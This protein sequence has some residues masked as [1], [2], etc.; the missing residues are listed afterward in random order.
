MWLSTMIPH[1]NSA[2][3]HWVSFL[4]HTGHR[5]GGLKQVPDCGDIWNDIPRLQPSHNAFP[6]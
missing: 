5:H 1:K 4:K 6:R 3:C 2:V